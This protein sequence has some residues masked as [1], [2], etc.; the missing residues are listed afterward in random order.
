[1]SPDIASLEESLAHDVDMTA[2]DVMT[3]EEAA[4]LVGKSAK[5]IQRWRDAGVGVTDRAALLAHSEEKDCRAKG[6]S[7]NRV[8]K[9]MDR[10]LRADSSEY[11]PLIS[12]GMRAKLLAASPDAFID[13]P[14]V[15]TRGQKENALATILA[16]CQAFKTR[17]DDLQS[18]G[19]ALS[20]EL[21][22]AELAEMNQI[23]SRL[24][25]ILDGFND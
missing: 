1:M 18:I 10:G 9:R 22:E 5:T 8:L 13:L 23:L 14:A 12:Q 16:L 15:I 25:A 17:L 2:H 20:I 6:A 19:H 24:E 21:A 4:R 11:T 3:I 7:K